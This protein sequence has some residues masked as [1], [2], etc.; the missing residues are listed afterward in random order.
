LNRHLNRWTRRRCRRWRY[1]RGRCR[2]CTWSGCGRCGCGKGGILRNRP[3]HG[4][5][6]RIVP[7]RVRAY[8]APSP[9]RE[10]VTASRRG[11]NRNRCSAVSPPTAGTYR[12][13]SSVGHRQEILRR[14]RRCVSDVGGGSNSV[15]DSSAIAPS[16]P[17][18]PNATGSA[19]WGSCS[20]GVA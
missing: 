10:T 7:P 11:T 9:I 4:G 8:S 1:R 5:R 18:V 17:Y 13:T 2:R 14:E 20:N 19:L 15:R 3:V 16:T 6:S 12:A